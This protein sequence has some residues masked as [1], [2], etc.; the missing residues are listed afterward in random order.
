MNKYKVLGLSFLLAIGFTGNAQQNKKSKYKDTESQ[1]VMSKDELKSF[2]KMVAEKRLEQLKKQDVD[3]LNYYA[4][5]PMP[6]RAQKSCGSCQKNDLASQVQKVNDRLDNLMLALIGK[7]GASN[8][9]VPGQGTSYL[10]NGTS[11]QISALEQ[12]LDSLKSLQ[13]SSYISP[14]RRS[15]LEELLAKYKNFK[16]QVFFA[17]DSYAVSSDDIAYINDV[18]KVL[19]QNPELSVMLEGYASNVGSA[20]YNNQL[21]MKR[22][23]A[24][25]KAL[26]DRGI[27]RDRLYSAFFGIDKNVPAAKAR[28]VDMTVVIK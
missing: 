14:E 11:S 8:V 23:E 2:L 18:A 17:N 15:A 3:S 22:A 20:E 25:K 5:A 24:I 7:G 9:V 26:A 10:D 6:R 16:R 4:V 19:K 1:I 12:R 13:N 28:R 27:S 21:S